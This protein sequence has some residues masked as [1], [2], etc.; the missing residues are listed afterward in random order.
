MILGINDMA[1]PSISLVKNGKLIFYV[2][3]ERLN[4]I[5]HSHNSFPIK[6]LEY[7]L[8]KFKLSIDDLQYISYNWDFNKYSGGFMKKYFKKINTKYK[9]DE[10]S[11]NWQIQRLKNRNLK[12]FKKRIEKNLR[13]KFSFKKL[14]E[15]KFFSHHYVHA[16]QSY[17]HS[18]FNNAICITID[19]SGEENSTVIWKCL[20]GKISKLKEINIPHSLGWYYAAFTEYLGFKA[21]DGEYKL[22]GLASYGNR[23]NFFKKKI[24]QILSINN[25]TKYYELNPKFI[26][27]GKHTYS[28]RFTDKLAKIFGREPRKS[29]DKIKKWHMDLAYE[30]QNK[31][32]EVILGIYNKYSFLTGIKNLVIGGGVGLNVK[33]NSKLY[34]QGNCEKIFPNPLCADNGAS[35]GSA[36]LADLKFNNN[37][38]KVLSTLAVGPEYSDKEIIKILTQNKIKFRYFTNIY[39]YTAEKIS[40][41]KVIAWFQ[42]KMEA[43]ARALGQRSI[44]GDPRDKNMANKIN[45]IIKYRELWRPFCPSILKEHIKDYFDS[46]YDSKFMTIS[47]KANSK[48][49]RIAPSIVHVDNTCRLQSVSKIHNA[50]FYSLINEFY[51]IT[52]VPILL[53]TSF[54]IKGEPIVCSPNDAIR[55]F[56]ATG[57]DELIINNFVIKK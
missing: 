17:Y 40:K 26:H 38:P 6:S 35:A 28:G 1:D 33:M 45:K 16:F 48:L 10:T 25:K 5:K 12:N 39:K 19:G 42:G 4:R 9:F 30:V 44:L 51:R 54:N 29:S 46:S 8:D 24:D 15:I 23:N 18:G 34:S 36:L 55:T 22:M 41:G 13:N 14:P 7:A 47:F 27:I 57:I 32:E 20:N 53:N 3:E 50:R 49:K 21:Y 52:N 37:K 2:E 43:G 31:L 56:Y 11:K